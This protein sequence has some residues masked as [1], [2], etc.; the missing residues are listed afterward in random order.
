MVLLFAGPFE[1]VG[2]LLGPLVPFLVP[3]KGPLE[4]SGLYFSYPYIQE[5]IRYSSENF[6]IVNA[7]IF[8]GLT[9]IGSLLFRR[10][11]CRFC[12]TGASIAVLNRFKGFT[13]SPMLHLDKTETKCTKC[14]VCKRVCPVQ[15]NEVYEKKGGKIKTSMCMLCLR[16][17]E[18]CPY[19]DCLKVKLGKK[20]IFK[21][22]NWLENSEID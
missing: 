4:L 3:W 7:L 14:G 19:E 21:S 20:V 11:W 18:M 15:V 5:V 16:C 8:L 1:Y 2:I 12:P 22:R 6:V 10:V 17:V 9:T 13:W